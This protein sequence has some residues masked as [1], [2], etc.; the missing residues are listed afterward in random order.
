MRLD[1]KEVNKIEEYNLLHS[2]INS[3][4]SNKNLNGHYSTIIQVCM[5]TRRGKEEFKNF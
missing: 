2:I 1:D 5:N 3:P 4:K